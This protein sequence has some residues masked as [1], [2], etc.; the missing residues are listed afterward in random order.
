M[1]FDVWV[2]SFGLSRVI[3]DLKM[4]RSPFNFSVVAGAM[5][6]DAYLLYVFF[7]RRA[8]LAADPRPENVVGRYASGPPPDS[9]RRPPGSPAA[10]P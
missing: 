1:S 10:A 7:T 6:L 2:V 3:V 4:M 9:P 5:I 8:R